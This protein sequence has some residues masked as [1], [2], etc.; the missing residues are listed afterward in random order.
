MTQSQNPAK[1]L[2]AEQLARL[3]SFVDQASDG[4]YLLDRDLNFV[5][6]NARALA[7]A[8]RTREELVGK[9]LADVVPDVRTSGRYTNQR[10]AGGRNRHGVGGGVRHRPQPWRCHR[11]RE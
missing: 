10:P 3:A 4:F 5:D 6:A 11:L 9:N 2:A 8:G 7:I 1:A